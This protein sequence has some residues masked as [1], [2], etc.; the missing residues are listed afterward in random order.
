M[1]SIE[2]V[3]GLFIILFVSYYIIKIVW[4]AIFDPVDPNRDK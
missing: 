4:Y 2:E 3:I 1:K